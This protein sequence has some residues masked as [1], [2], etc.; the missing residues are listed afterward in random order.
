MHSKFITLQK[1]KDQTVLTPKSITYLK[2]HNRGGNVPIG[3]AEDCNF[4]L[5]PPKRSKRYLLQDISTASFCAK[6]NYH[7]KS[8]N[9]LLNHYSL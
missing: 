4:L 5:L 2:T 1:K 8:L 7:K 3:V 9:Y 6:P